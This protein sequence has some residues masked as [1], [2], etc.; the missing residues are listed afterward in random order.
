MNKKKCQKKISLMKVV[1]S[2]SILPCIIGRDIAEDRLVLGRSPHRELI[3]AQEEAVVDRVVLLDAKQRRKEKGDAKVA[4]VA[5]VGKAELPHVGNKAPFF[6]LRMAEDPSAISAA[7]MTL[8][9][10]SIFRALSPGSR[11]DS[12]MASGKEERSGMIWCF[13]G[14]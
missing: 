10:G 9:L 2:T 13:F 3:Q 14:R 1:D 6:W 8:A 5:G 4:L 11:D 12:Q 7:I